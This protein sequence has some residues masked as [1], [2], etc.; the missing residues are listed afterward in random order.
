MKQGT[1]RIVRCAILILLVTAML[2]SFGCT[3]ET[4]RALDYSLEN[5]IMAGEPEPTPGEPAPD[6]ATATPEVT[7]EAV[8][9]PT[10]DPA[11]ATLAPTDGAAPLPQAT[12]ATETPLPTQTPQLHRLIVYVED[13]GALPLA[14]ARVTLYQDD[15]L[16]YSGMTGS[17][18]YVSW[19]LPVD[20]T[21]RVKATLSG[22][23][24]I[25]GFDNAYTMTQDVFAKI[26]LAKAATDGTILPT[27][28]P[29]PVPDGA[30]GNVSITCP[31]MT[32]EP[33]QAGFSLLDYVSARTEFDQPVAVWVVD[34]GGFRAETPG[35]YSV[36][37]GALPVFIILLLMFINPDYINIFFETQSGRIMLIVS[38]VLEVIGFLFVRRIVNIKM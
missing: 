16:L 28:T 21:Y 34:N 14:G 31:D 38:V 35:V 1:Q 5:E 13:N 18:G 22:Y 15:S 30:P 19:M 2:T 17:D 11:A 33:G 12:D 10:P 6:T 7:P 20:Y 8:P 26:T 29:L 32:I 23:Q 25:S 4:V 9:T 27:P 3:G 37:Y 24:A 36:T